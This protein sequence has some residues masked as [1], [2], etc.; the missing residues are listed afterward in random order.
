MNVLFP[1]VGDSVGGSQRS[2]IELYQGL[3]RLNGV[4]PSIVLHQ[5]GGPLS[6]VLNELKIPFHVLPLSDLA[7]E[8][9]ALV[10]IAKSAIR[11]SAP[12]RS[13]LQEHAIDIV[14]GNNLRI[15]LTWSFATRFSRTKFVWHQRTVLS[16]SPLWKGIRFLSDFFVPI[17][18]YV[19]QSAPTNLIAHRR[20]MILNPFV[21]EKH[22]QQQAREELLN[23][24]RIPLASFIVGFLGRLVARKNIEQLIRAFARFHQ[25]YD[26]AVLVIVGTGSDDYVDRLHQLISRLGVSDQVHF[27][28]FRSDPQ[29]VLSGFDLLVSPNLDEGFGRVLVEGMLQKIPVVAVA[30]GG[31]MEIIED[32][33]TGLLY[34]VGDDQHLVSQMLRV[35][36]DKALSEVLVGHAFE[37]AQTTYSRDRHVERMLDVYYSLNTV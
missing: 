8:K 33:L 29:R 28:G 20:Q 24:C 16:Q 7:G 15:N 11:C 1:F 30:S 17:S 5:D 36:S 18:N 2:I 9:P 34:E 21:V 26:D 32:G 23:E 35:R 25:Q 31:H 6:A 37:H 14:H 3:N 4:V 22:D 13:F 12:I 19:D 10:Y 27:T